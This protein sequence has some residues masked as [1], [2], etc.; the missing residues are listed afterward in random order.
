M[1]DRRLPRSPKFGDTYPVRD[2][3]PYTARSRH[4]ARRPD[5][6]NVVLT[7]IDDHIQTTMTANNLN[8]TFASHRSVLSQSVP[9]GTTI[10]MFR[11]L[12]LLVAGLASATASPQCKCF[13]GDACW[14]SMSVWEDFNATVGGRLIANEPLA[15]PCH[16][17]NYDEGACSALREQWLFGGVQ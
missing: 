7:G 6:H 8:P 16:S 14:P 10:A 1:F 15:A 11:V 9:R 12:V 3:H 5:P 13:P 17:P 4:Q 2:G